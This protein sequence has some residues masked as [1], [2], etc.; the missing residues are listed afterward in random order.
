MN[1]PFENLSKIDL[2]LEKLE[3]LESKVTGEKR[4]LNISETAHYLG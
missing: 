3:I 2:L 4:W 1:I